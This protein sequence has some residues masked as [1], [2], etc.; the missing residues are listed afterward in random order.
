MSDTAPA[1][2]SLTARHAIDAL[3]SMPVDEL[4][5]LAVHLDAEQRIVK[6]VLRERARRPTGRL[7]IV[8]DEPTPAA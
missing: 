3:V 5:R 7:G 1:L 4:R 2:E 8:G 6:T